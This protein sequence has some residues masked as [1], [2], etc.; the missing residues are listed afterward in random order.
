MNAKQALAQAR[1]RWGKKAAVEDYRVPSSP[2]IRAEAKAELERIKAMPTDDLS[3]DELREV[4]KKADAARS[5]SW[6]FRY[7]VGYI[8]GIGGLMSVFHVSGQ[9]DSWDEA[10]AKADAAEKRAA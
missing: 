5:T 10:F 8:D 2:E 9:G 3:K 6:R 7:S 1:K 4:R